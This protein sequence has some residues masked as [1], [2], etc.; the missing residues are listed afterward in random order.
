MSKLTFY[1]SAMNAGKSAQLLQKNHNLSTK[2]FSTKIYRSHFDDRYGLGKVTSRIGIQAD[3]LLFNDTTSFLEQE[4]GDC[5]FY[6]VRHRRRGLA[7]RH[8]RAVPGRPERSA[9]QARLDAGAAPAPPPGPAGRPRGRRGLPPRAARHRR[10]H[11]DAPAPRRPRPGFTPLARG[12]IKP[13]RKT[14]KVCCIVI[15]CLV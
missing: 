1:Y 7:R 4:Y 14:K 2:G 12:W 11:N 5:Q 13:E 9:R 15:S 3:A 6:P 10:W 8:A